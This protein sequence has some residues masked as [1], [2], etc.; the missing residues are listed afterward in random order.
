MYA[1]L[2]ELFQNVL[3]QE[4]ASS[5]STTRLQAVVHVL[6]VAKRGISVTASLLPTFGL[7]ACE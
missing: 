2:S 4:A 3:G 7:C 5:P 6:S 1:V